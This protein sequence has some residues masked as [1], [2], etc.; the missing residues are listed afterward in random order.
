MGKSG[1][2]AAAQSGAISRLIS[3]ALRAGVNPEV[4]IK[5]LRGTRCPAPAWQDGGIVLSCPDAIGIALEKYL[6]EKSG[7]KE[8]FKINHY[9]EEIFN[10]NCPECG[11]TL[12][13]EGEC[14][15]C[16]VCGYSKCL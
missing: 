14:N 11:S 2:C 12:E 3:V 10:E 7:S 15:I 16:R 8:K 4:I 13:H 5:H 9:K 6:H 1:G